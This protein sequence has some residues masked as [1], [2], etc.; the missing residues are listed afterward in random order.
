M[1]SETKNYDCRSPFSIEGQSFTN[2]NTQ[3]ST[4]SL[5]EAMTHSINVCFIKVAQETGSPVVR[6]K[7]TEFGFDM[8][9]WWQS[10]QNDEVQLAQASLGENIPVTVESL[11]QS[12]A[13]LANKGRASGHTAVISENTAASVNHMLQNVVLRGT[14]KNAAIPGVP[15]AGK[16][17][18]VIENHENHL[19]LFAGFAPADTPRYVIL[20]VIEDGQI[21][22]KA[23]H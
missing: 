8:S 6:T 19:A 14:G 4:A 5:G 9:S 21:N 22:K 11:I 20:V 10:N 18:T 12:Y 23:A 7:L 1:S 13:I 15:V 2:Y 3:V 16:T 17:G